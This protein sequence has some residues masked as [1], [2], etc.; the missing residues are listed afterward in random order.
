M[1]QLIKKAVVGESLRIQ[2]QKS[3]QK[4]PNRSDFRQNEVVGTKL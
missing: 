3:E 4:L 2:C 1:S